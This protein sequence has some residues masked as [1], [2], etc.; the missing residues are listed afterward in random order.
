M[1]NCK[2]F[3]YLI[4]LMLVMVMGIML[5]IIGQSWRIVMQREREAELLFRGSQIKD[6][7]TRW[8]TPRPGQPAAMPLRDLND[9]LRDPR[10]ASTVRYLRRLYNDPITGKEWSVISDP[11][12]GISGVASTSQ[13][14]PLKVD[15][16]PDGLQ[17]LAGKAHYS[18]WQFVYLGP[19]AQQG[20]TGI[21]APLQ[22]QGAAA[23]AATPAPQPG[24]TP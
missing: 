23:P 18:E 9:L 3:T 12:R 8:Y 19:G 11:S 5:G 16:F 15:G 2:G 17:D 7:I 24:A 6:A 13:D 1:N 20:G 22:P 4:A 10:S 21:P 14:K